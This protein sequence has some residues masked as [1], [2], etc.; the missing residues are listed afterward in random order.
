[1]IVGELDVAHDAAVGVAALR[2]AQ[3]HAHHHRGSIPPRA[4]ITSQSCAHA[5][6]ALKDLLQPDYQ[7][8]S[9]PN[10]GHVPINCGT[11]VKLFERSTTRN[12]PERTPEVSD[13]LPE[14]PE[15]VT[16]PDDIS[17]L[18]RASAR[19]P[20][21]RARAVR[22]LGWAPAV[23]AVGVGAVAVALIVRGD[24][25]TTVREE[26]PWPAAVEGPGSNSLNATPVTPTVI[27]WPNVTEGPGS[28]SLN[29]TSVTPTVIAWPNVTEG[30]GSNS[31]AP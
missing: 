24:D 21:Q 31:L 25:T 20:S 3:I 30:P 1:M 13:H 27:A 7:A 17:S 5:F 14:L 22:W 8:L 15:G 4:S 12:V 28:N 6:R 23:L 2:R 18:D 19:G 29:A 26:I 9:A 16:V 10:P 11:R